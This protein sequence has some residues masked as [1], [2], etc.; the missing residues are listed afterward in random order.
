MVNKPCKR[1]FIILIWTS[2]AYE[3]LFHLSSIQETNTKA[4]IDAY[5]YKK[6]M[7]SV[8]LQV[9]NTKVAYDCSKIIYLYQSNRQMPE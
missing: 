9:M 2:V 5:L 7:Q 4:Q 3:I 8:K 1:A 6:R